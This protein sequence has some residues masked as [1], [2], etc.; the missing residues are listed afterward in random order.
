MT[1]DGYLY[2]AE[3]LLKEFA[4]T[5]NPSGPFGSHH[6]YESRQASLAITAFVAANFQPE[7]FPPIKH[8]NPNDI[9]AA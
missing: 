3:R 9:D 7:F 6:S 2:E 1:R 5:Y 8:D 4:R